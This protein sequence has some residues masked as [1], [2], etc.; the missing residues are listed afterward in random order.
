[1][2]ILVT[3]SLAYDTIMDFPGRFRDHILPDQIHVLNTCFLVDGIVKNFGGCAGNIAYTMRMLGADPI[4]LSVLGSDG[5]TYSDYLE[6][7]GIVTRYIYREASALSS[8]ATI[9]TDKDDN[10]ITAYHNG[11]SDAASDLSIGDMDQSFDFAIIAPTKKTAM[12]KY[13]SECA[14]RKTPFV[15]DP[16][17]Q[18]GGFEKDELRKMLSLCSFFI[19]NDYELKVTEQKTEYSARMLCAMIDTVIITRGASGSRIITRRGAEHI[20]IV[21]CKPQEVRD[22]TGAGDAY[23]AGF[24]SAYAAGKDLAVCGQVGS[25]AAA[26]AIER[27][28]TQNHIFSI[29]D[30]EQRY[31]TNYAS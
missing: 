11:A 25:V 1:M 3:G 14:A 20:E 13:A 5:D 6:K 12:I 18:L 9:I 29:K 26:Y 23:R 19:V 4:V 10:Q 17:Q 30:F 24:F 2:S 15:F 27:Y 22:P 7:Q 31:G 8:Q 16:G 28:G 21:P